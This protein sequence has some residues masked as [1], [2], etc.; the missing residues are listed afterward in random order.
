MAVRHWTHRLD[1]IVFIEGCQQHGVEPDRPDAVF[2]LFAAT[3]LAG[4][5]S[6]LRAERVDPVD[7]LRAE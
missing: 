3:V 2:G 4:M 5:R 6:A 1:V 7:T